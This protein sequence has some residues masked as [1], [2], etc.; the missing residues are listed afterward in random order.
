MTV[1]R[2]SDRTIECRQENLRLQYSQIMEHFRQTLRG[3]TNAVFMM[4]AILGV[5]VQVA[6]ISD[7]DPLIKMTVIL[8]NLLLNFLG[9][10]VGF[11]VI[12]YFRFQQRT[13]DTISGELGLTVDPTIGYTVKTV[14]VCLVGLAITIIF[15]LFFLVKGV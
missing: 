3:G 1:Q 4:L 12:R 11:F 6:L 10:L 13:I 9:G 8:C 2:R 5:S 14:V 15:W 7:A